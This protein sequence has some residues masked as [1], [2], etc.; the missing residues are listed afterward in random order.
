[1]DEPLQV[2]ERRK[3][4][5]NVEVFRGVSL[6]LPGGEES[7]VSGSAILLTIFVG[8]VARWTR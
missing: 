4:N 7:F 3:R 5:D 2:S 8:G 1:M 6:A